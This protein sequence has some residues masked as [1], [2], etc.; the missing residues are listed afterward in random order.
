M[1]KTP[2]PNHKPKPNLNRDESKEN[3]TLKPNQRWQR[4]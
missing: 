2:K 4:K 1:L 3:Q